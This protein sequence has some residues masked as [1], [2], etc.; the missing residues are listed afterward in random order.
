MKLAT[1]PGTISTLT[2]QPEAMVREEIL[3]ADAMLMGTDRAKYAPALV[4]Y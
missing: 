3:R 4:I 2:K 1:T